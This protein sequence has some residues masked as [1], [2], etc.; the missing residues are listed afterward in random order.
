MQLTITF[1]NLEASETLKEHAKERVERVTRHLDVAGV[2]HV[3]F[4]LE[5][6]LH[7]ADVTV[8]AGPLLLRAGH[9]TTDMG[10][11][12]DLACDRLEEQLRREKDRHKHHHAR[13]WVHHQLGDF[14]S[15][16]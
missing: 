11:S 14:E 10:V 12:L 7:W 8:A 4:W 16:G 3:V 1:R 9:A 5:R 13:D 2:A 15:A 6:H